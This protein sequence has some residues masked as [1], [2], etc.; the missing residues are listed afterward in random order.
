MPE[1]SE[2]VLVAVVVSARRRR[3]SSEEHLTAGLVAWG[4]F[5]RFEARCAARVVGFG[6]RDRADD[7]RD[8]IEVLERGV[9]AG[10]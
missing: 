9:A 5:E 7:R 8:D 4:V 2:N 1:N 10:L 3:M 6:V